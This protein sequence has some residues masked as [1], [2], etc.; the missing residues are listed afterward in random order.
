MLQ[1][2]SPRINRAGQAPM[3][4]V[5][6]QHH[7]LIGPMPV[8]TRVPIGPLQ[9]HLRRIQQSQSLLP[10]LLRG[11]KLLQLDH[12]HIQI[13]P[14]KHRLI[15][16]ER[17]PPHAVP[18]RVPRPSFEMRRRERPHERH[19]VETLEGP[20]RR[21]EG[22]AVTVGVGEVGDV[23]ELAVAAANDAAVLVVDG[24]AGEPVAGVDDQ[25]IEL[26]DLSRP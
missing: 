23:G 12:I 26:V 10:P 17:S 9:H 20:Q 14:V 11:P 6:I 7:L 15:A 18:A 25:V 24:G 4:A 19:A 16:S 22:A 1:N 21:A 3:H 8:P 5:M 2:V 13:Q